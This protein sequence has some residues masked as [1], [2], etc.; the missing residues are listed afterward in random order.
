VEVYRQATLLD[1]LSAEL[2]NNMGIALL[3][4]ERFDEAEK[5]FNRAIGIEQEYAE[6]YFNLGNLYRKL[7][8][9]QD[10]LKSYRRFLDVWK[11]GEGP[12]KRAL[13]IIRD[14]ESDG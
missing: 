4:L 1:T 6:P 5:S 9:K 8:R 10:A 14:L 12:R 3:G 7:D 13:R 2:F 11:G